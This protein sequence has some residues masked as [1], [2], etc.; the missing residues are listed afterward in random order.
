M[1]VLKEKDNRE[2]EK[3]GSDIADTMRLCTMRQC[4]RA[5]HCYRCY[6]TYTATMQFR[7]PTCSSDTW[8][9]NRLSAYTARTCSSNINR[10]LHERSIYTC[11]ISIG[12]CSM[13]LKT[14]QSLG[15]RDLVIEIPRISPATNA[16][17]HAIE[18][19]FRGNNAIENAI[20]VDKYHNFEWVSSIYDNSQRF[21]IIDK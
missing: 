13:I 1:K 14:S 9:S 12:L 5:R 15:E 7:R 10:V 11:W 18:M 3:G 4:I 21:Y 8:L 20:E 19:E 2:R 6:A 16:K 17:P